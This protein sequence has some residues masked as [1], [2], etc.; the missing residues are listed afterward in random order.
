MNN[1]RD[2]S[3]NNNQSIRLTE[4]KKKLNLNLEPWLNLPDDLLL[5]AFRPSVVPISSKLRQDLKEKYDMTNLEDLEFLGDAVIEFIATQIVF[6]Y[7]K[8]GPGFMT[9]RRIEF[10][11]NTSLY[12]IMSKLNLCD[13]TENRGNYKIKDC[14]DIFEALIGALYYYLYYLEE[15]KD[16]MDVIE[17]YVKTNFY[18]EELINNVMDNNKPIDTCKVND[19]QTADQVGKDY[20]I[21]RNPI[22]IIKVNPVQII[23]SNI[24]PVRIISTFTNKPEKQ[25]ITNNAKLLCS[26]VQILSQNTK[27]QI[28]RLATIINK[29]YL[30]Y[31]QDNLKAKIILEN[32]YKYLKLENYL[33]DIFTPETNNE[34]KYGVTIMEIDFQKLT[35]KACNIGI[36]KTKDEA[37][38]EASKEVLLNIFKHYNLIDDLEV[39][40][41]ENTIEEPTRELTLEEIL[42]DLDELNDNEPIFEKTLSEFTINKLQEII[43]TPNLI[44]NYYLNFKEYQKANLKNQVRFNYKEEKLNK[45]YEILESLYKFLGFDN[46]LLDIDELIIMD[47]IDITNSIRIGYYIENYDELK[48]NKENIINDLSVIALEDFFSY[49]GMK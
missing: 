15:R 16:Y 24:N 22:A 29:Y 6:D 47:K 48:L 5:M 20:M 13:L 37:I 1:Y 38:L 10:I 31:N 4:I 21:N 33:F 28:K 41:K 23:P 43:K 8:G 35:R 40:S 34:N 12:C 39:K 2:V 9:V 44:N 17:S 18:T 26:R 11:K 25:Q 14:A 46:Y 49:F 7:S 19:K 30:D 45:P 3:Q 36:G 27:H 32:L 42:Q